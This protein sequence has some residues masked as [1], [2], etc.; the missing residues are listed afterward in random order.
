MKIVSLDCYNNIYQ[1]MSGIYFFILGVLALTNIF[2]H[3]SFTGEKSPA[4][5]FSFIFI[6]F[7]S[8]SYGPGRQS[9]SWGA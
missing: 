2:F 8:A 4:H 9:S 6:C 7:L 3:N 5:I 1:K